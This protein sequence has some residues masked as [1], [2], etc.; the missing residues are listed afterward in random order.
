VQRTVEYIAGAGIGYKVLK[1]V[2]GAGTHILPSPALSDYQIVPDDYSHYQTVLSPSPA[3]TFASILPRPS[4]TPFVNFVPNRIT[5]SY[6]PIVAPTAFAFRPTAVN[7][8]Y[9]DNNLEHNSNN[10]GDH[11]YKVPLTSGFAATGSGGTSGSGSYE[12]TS[13]E[14]HHDIP[15]LVPPYKFPSG[16]GSESSDSSSSQEN[17]N[18]SQ[19]SQ[20][21]AEH[22]Q[23]PHHNSQE[24]RDD[25]DQSSEY[26]HY[27]NPRPFRP[28]GGNPNQY[29]PTKPS[30][31]YG[32]KIPYSH[33]NQV[34]GGGGGGPRVIGKWY[35]VPSHDVKVRARVQNIDYPAHRAP[36][37]SDALRR[38]EENEYHER[39]HHHQHQH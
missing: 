7:P 11:P 17:S 16:T 34:N 26:H 33:P 28:S 20:E 1:S 19:G 21:P 30:L 14:Q 2:E 6:Q 10:G 31:E 32:D 36:S 29:H 22:R 5:P 39:R 38:D 35:P 27:N 13:N 37:P 15:G 8:T 23:R 25:H 9:H 18:N 4:P 3:P 12:H 24:H